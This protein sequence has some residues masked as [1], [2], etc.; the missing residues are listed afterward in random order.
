MST[1]IKNIRII[2]P[3]EVLDGYSVVI[4]GVKIINID[5]EE[6]IKA[7]LI[8]ETIDGEG[9]FLSPGFIDIH[10]HG[11]S[12]YDFMDGTEEAI[13]K[14][15]QFHL[16]NGVTS[17]LGTVLTSSYDDICNA[18]Q[19]IANY[20]NKD[21][22]S[23]LLGIHLEGP[24]LSVQKKG[25]Q[26][27][28]HIKEP[29]LEFIKK[30]KNISLNKLKMVSIAPEKRGAV[31]II[32]YLKLNNITVA[33]AHSNATYDEAKNGINHGATVTTHLFNGM[34]DFNHRE[35]GIIGASLLD[36]RVYCEIIYDRI[37][38]HDGAVLIALKTKGADNI[39]SVS[40]A[41]RASGLE[42][43][44]YELGGQRVTVNMGAA[45]LESG[46]LAGSTLNLRN[47]VYNMVHFLNIPMQDAVKMATLS[48]AK[49]I[50]VD[51]NKGS[52]E[53]GK[54]AD[55][56]FLD[57]DINILSVMVGGHLIDIY[58]RKK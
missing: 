7:D 38:L 14:I 8:S 53:I 37:H 56:L 51:S 31:E 42:D 12:G 45:R 5:L 55:L 10:N 9:K 18:V 49:A 25:A 46:N 24:F 35:P 54:D 15:G 32:D 3:Y 34:R 1:L 30:I 28:M 21:Y 41:M 39:I 22:L 20:K 19:N 57:N 27:E 58:N 43:G 50:G 11:N 47:A 52:I 2:T 44:M 40:D 4:D 33:M 17:Y 16:M 29:E 23:Q 6:N 26:P 36:D 13:D 48:P